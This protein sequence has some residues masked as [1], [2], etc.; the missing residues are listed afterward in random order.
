M[1]KDVSLLLNAVGAGNCFLLSYTYLLKREPKRVRVS[2]ILSL[3]FFVIGAA[4]LNTILN[5]SGYSHLLYGFEPLSNALI[6]AIAPLLFL[7]VRSFKGSTDRISLWSAHLA[8][9]YVFLAV[10]LLSLAVPQGVLGL[11]A[12]RIIGSKWTIVFWNLHFYKL[13]VW[14]WTRISK[15]E[16]AT[17]PKRLDHNLGNS[18]HMVF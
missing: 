11:W 6:F 16:K 1:I 15:N 14:D 8:L 12:Q 4:I 9:F 7:Y 2:H 5:F 10:T 17:W 3:L 13:F 18:I